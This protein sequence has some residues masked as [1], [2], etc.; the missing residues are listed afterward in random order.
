[1]LGG[2]SN[3][4]G[5]REREREHVRANEQVAKPSS[6]PSPWALF[7]G[8]MEKFILVLFLWWDEKF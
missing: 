6:S 8:V 4:R 3:M 1:M 5:E 7:I 2:F